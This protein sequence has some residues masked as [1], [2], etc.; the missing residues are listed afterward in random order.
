M[1]D[2]LLRSR[3]WVVVTIP[4]WEW[5]KLGSLPAKLA[6]LRATLPSCLLQDDLPA[7]KPSARSS[8]A[9]RE[10]PSSTWTPTRRKH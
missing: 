4:F 10:E 6:Y 1:R 3:G 7:R 9:K 2:D 8:K 5:D